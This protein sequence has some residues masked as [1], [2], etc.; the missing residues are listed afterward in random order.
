MDLLQHFQ[1]LAYYNRIANE[2]LYERCAELS[3]DE[4]RKQRAGS[5]GSIHGLLN[6][7]LLGDRIWTS[8]F[9]GSGA[10]TPPLN[11]VLFED[12]SALRA[13]RADQDARIEAFFASLPAEAFERK[14]SY[15]NSQGKDYV[16]SAAVAF[17]HFFNHQ[18]H[19]QGA[20]HS[21]AQP[22]SGQ[23][24]IAP[25]L[26]QD[27]ESLKTGLEPGT[28][29]SES[30]APHRAHLHPRTFAWRRQAAS[31]KA[32]YPRSDPI[33]EPTSMSLRKC[34]PTMTR[35]IATFAASTSSSIIASG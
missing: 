30:P 16:E 7:M 27:C 21:H 12:F 6:H 24:A 3:D 10:T 5:F 22:D 25:I 2:R 29:K 11:T 1:T 19:H 28:P 23:A 34:I 31:L 32:T 35:E 20:N 4:Y 8:R 33:A 15:V 9:E 13:A 26:A 17:P 18:T 14:F